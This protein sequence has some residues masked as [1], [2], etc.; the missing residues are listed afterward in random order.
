MAS[1]TVFGWSGGYSGLW[2]PMVGSAVP[3]VS[4][5]G[6]SWTQA[7]AVDTAGTPTV[8]SGSMVEFEGPAGLL[9]VFGPGAYMCECY[10]A[11]SI[12]GLW[13]SAD[14]ASWKPEDPKA[15]FG[16][17]VVVGVAARPSGY[18]AV[19]R[20]EA[21]S[22]AIWRS[23]D[24]RTWDAVDLP[25]SIFENAYFQRVGAF[26]G[27]FVASGSIGVPDG[28][29]GDFRVITPAMW[30]SADGSSWTRV[31]V[32]GAVAGP[33]TSAYVASGGGSEPLITAWIRGSG[34]D[35]TRWISRDGQAWRM[36]VAPAIVGDQPYDFGERML[37]VARPPSSPGEPEISVLAADSS[38]KPLAQTGDVP[39]DAWSGYPTVT[40]GPTGL[41][42]CDGMTTRTVAG[43]D[44]PQMSLQPIRCWLAVPTAA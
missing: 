39:A 43:S 32:P 36:T 17:D 38:I 1:F 28:Q 29:L 27:G 8:G 12:N 24:A 44:G 20:T 4:S 16:S 2:F 19:G 21:G 5:D 23:S 7:P 30:W 9:A 3:W 37:L 25:T 22:P 14:G 34:S 18:V 42:V 6:L 35:A 13:T 40:L 33:A 15:A 41:L 26:A 10:V 11:G 31:T